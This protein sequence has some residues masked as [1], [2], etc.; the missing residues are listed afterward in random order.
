MEKGSIFFVNGKFQNIEYPVL[1]WF[2]GFK[3]YAPATIIW[4]LSAF[5]GRIRIFGVCDEIYLLY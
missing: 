5:F 2:R 4:V 3:G 1:V